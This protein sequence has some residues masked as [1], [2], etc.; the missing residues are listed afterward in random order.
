M[1]SR[2]AWLSRLIL[3]GPAQGFDL[4]RHQ[5]SLLMPARRSR[6]DRV[7]P[8]FGGFDQ[9]QQFAELAA[10]LEQR[11]ADVAHQVQRRDDLRSGFPNKLIEQREHADHEGF[12][13]YR[14]VGAVA[15]HRP[16]ISAA[17]RPPRSAADWS[18]APADWPA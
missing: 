2:Y 18:P 6:A 5:A 11:L 14:L 12:V 16:S 13:L 15:L 4:R 9:G 3:Q 1:A 17:R 10:A 7:G 8:A